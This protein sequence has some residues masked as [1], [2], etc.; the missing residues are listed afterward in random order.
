MICTEP[1]KSNTYI[2]NNRT[3]IEQMASKLGCDA[4]ELQQQVDMLVQIMLSEVKAGNSITVKNFGVF[5][6]KT[7][8]ERRMYN[9]STKTYSTIP[10]KQTVS[11]KMGAALKDKIQK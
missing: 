3:F 9:P 11:F 10:A 4:N 8:A 6:Q 5:E 1:E 7:K 2:M